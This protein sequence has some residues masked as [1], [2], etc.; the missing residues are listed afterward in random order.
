MKNHLKK[1]S[2]KFIWKIIWKIRWSSQ[3]RRVCGRNYW[4]ETIEKWF[5]NF[6]LSNWKFQIIWRIFFI[7]VY[8]YIFIYVKILLLYIFYISFISI[9]FILYLYLLYLYLLFSIDGTI[10]KVQLKFSRKVQS[11]SSVEVEKF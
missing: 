11:K 8:Y 6:F 2:E 1:S 3:K 7:Y 5:L 4:V 10:R 9:S